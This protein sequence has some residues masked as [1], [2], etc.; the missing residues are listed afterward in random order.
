MASHLNVSS[1]TSGAPATPPQTGP[2]PRDYGVT[3]LALLPR[4]PRWLYA[5]W[6]IAPYTWEEARRAFGEQVSRGRAVLRMHSDNAGARET[7]DVDIALDTRHW[8]IHAP[9]G[10]GQWRAELGLVLP[11]GRFVLLAISNEVRLPSG[12]VSDLEDERWGVLR[13]LWDKLF[14]LSGGGR[15]GVGSIDMA[16]TLAHRWDLLRGGSS[17]SSSSLSSWA[18]PADK[19]KGFWLVADC[20]VT[21]YGATEPDA[22]VTF[23]GKPVRLNADGSFSFRFALPDGALDFPIRATNA[24]GDLSRG[25]SFHVARASEKDP[26]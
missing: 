15:V 21:V 16:K 5:Y 2:L 22:R 14:E 7:F 4:D 20:E 1:F 12:Q 11:D 9:H 18:K 23:Q 25:V 19:S 24:D 3:R 17:G 26:R 13:A 8:Y 10:G 6:E